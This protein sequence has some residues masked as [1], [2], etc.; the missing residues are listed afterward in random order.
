MDEDWD[1]E[2][3][4]EEACTTDGLVDPRPKPLERGFWPES[5]SDESYVPGPEEEDEDD[6]AAPLNS[7][8]FFFFLFLFLF[9]A[10]H[11]YA[12]PKTSWEKPMSFEN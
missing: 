2:E 4:E 11:C 6:A 10:C 1:E 5:S 8:F 9:I 12:M 3:V 7:F